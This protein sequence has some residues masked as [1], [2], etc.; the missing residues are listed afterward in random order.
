MASCRVLGGGRGRVEYKKTGL[1][2][3]KMFEIPAINANLLA[4]IAPTS[5]I[6]MSASPSSL[7]FDKA[8]TAHIAAR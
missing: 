4:T 2:F 5:E 8:P 6:A 3:T 7:S 1:K